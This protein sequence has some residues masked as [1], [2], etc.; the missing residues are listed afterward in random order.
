[1]GRRWEENIGGGMP[2]YW[3]F[4]EKSALERGVKARRVKI[5]RTRAEAWYSWN[6]F[7]V[8]EE[9]AEQRVG[10]TRGTIGL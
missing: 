3:I 7:E 9:L 1:M 4:A 2:G 10:K 8:G 5:V 6:R